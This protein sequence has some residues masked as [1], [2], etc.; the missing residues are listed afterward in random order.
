M[1]AATG[2]PGGPLE[3]WT[4]EAKLDGWRAIVGVRD[5]SVIVRTRRGRNVTDQLP[6]LAQLS[7]LGVDIVLDG[8]IIAGGGR[9]AE[10]YEL[11]GAMASR[12][13]ASP[14]NF[15]AFDLLALDGVDL[16][17]LPHDQRRRLLDHLAGLADGTVPVVSSHAGVD[18]DLVL[19]ACEHL[20][21]EGVVLKR[22]DA[23]YRPGRRSTAWRKLRCAG[24]EQH[25]TRSAI[26][27]SSL[28]AVTG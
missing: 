16:C 24:F 26:S 14:L 23:T 15:V 3:D 5:G 4:V 9:P 17:S 18:V 2:R 22:R 1:L 25:R 8:E 27:A 28:G 10:F 21:M 13:R 7:Q 19:A 11:A 6:E 12:R 20:A